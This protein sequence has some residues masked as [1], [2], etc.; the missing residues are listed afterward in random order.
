[1]DKITSSEMISK[2][3][4]SSSPDPILILDPT[5]VIRDCNEATEK[6]Y[7][8]PKDEICGKKSFHFFTEKSRAIF[9]E[10]FPL[11]VKGKPQEGEVDVV[12]KEGAIVSLWRKGVPYIDEEGNFKGVIIFDRDISEKKLSEDKLK[13]QKEYLEDKFDEQTSRIE[14][15][16][17]ELRNLIKE[18]RNTKEEN[19]SILNAIPDMLFV[20]GKDGEYLDFSY[21]DS[22]G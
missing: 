7:G 4:F 10:K 1:M 22:T 5:G 13:E 2:I 18:L 12:T 9:K 8:Y 3:L 19:Q 16:N 6:T 17:N 11:I 20:F 15:T 21:E 14:T